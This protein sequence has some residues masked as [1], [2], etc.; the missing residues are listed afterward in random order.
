MWN[1]DSIQAF[2][3]LKRATMKIPM[4]ALSGF[5]LSFIIETDALGVGLVALLTQE[6]KRIVYFSL[7]LSS[8]DQAKSIY[9]GENSWLWYLA[10]QKWRHYIVIN[11][12]GSLHVSRS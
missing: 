4:L 5:S 3:E 7:T 10:I 12:N 8:R 11:Q 9:D 1:D 2:E 6:S